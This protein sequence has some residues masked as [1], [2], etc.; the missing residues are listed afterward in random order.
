MMA[1]GPASGAPNAR[2]TI[3]EEGR[4]P[5]EE[6]ASLAVREGWRPRPE[7]GAHRWFA[8]RFGSAVRAILTGA[9][10]PVDGE[11]WDAYYA[12]TDWTGR[13]VLD[14]FVGGGTSV[15]EARRLG[16]RVI[17]V[18]VDPVACAITGWQ[19][20]A[21]TTPDLRPALNQL[22]VRVGEALAPYYRTTSPGHECDVLHFFWVQQVTCRECGIVAEAHP[23]YQL[24]H[25]AEGMRQWAFCRHCHAIQD[26]PRTSDE[27]W[28][29][30]CCATTRVAEGVV[31]YGRFTCPCCRQRERLIDSAARL[32]R[33]QWRLF[34]L[35]VL[36][37]AEGR[38]RLSPR[39]TL[40]RATDTDRANFAAAATALRQRT[41]PDGTVPWI[42]ERRIPTEQRA[43]DRVL[44][45]GYERYRDLFNSR[46]LLHLSC[47]A[48]AIAD[49]DG[50]ARD[51]M[52][53]AFSDHLTTNCMLT[54]YAFGWR[55]LA[56][57][58]SVRAYRHVVRPVELNPWLDRIGRGTFP[59]A[60]RQVQRAADAARA[61]R[62]PT[63]DGG[64][65]PAP[66]R[67][68]SRSP[69]Q[70]E[71]VVA[72]ARRL[73]FIADASVD[74]VLTDP[75]YFDNIPYAELSDFFRPWL[76]QFGLVRSEGALRVTPLDNLAALDR[77]ERTATRFAQE[78]AVCMREVRRVLAPAGKLA[79]T[80]QHSTAAG[81]QALASALN[82]AGFR[83]VQIFPLLGDRTAGL[84]ARAGTIRWDAVF[85]AAPSER[86]ERRRSLEV[87]EAAKVAADRHWRRWYDRLA[88]L[89]FRE[90][91]RLNLRRAC[92]VAAALSMFSPPEALGATQ[93]LVSLLR[94]A[95]EEPSVGEEPACLT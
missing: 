25:Q 57:L 18:D 88:D 62:E 40:L 92:L 70:A 9:A 3:L 76:Q 65:R 8:R 90:P 72:D 15:A 73:H 34:A 14:P 19:L 36:E 51:A 63:L 31:R 38:R 87:S 23:H 66:G 91:D 75:P 33:P 2:A 24:A 4:L 60:V 55:R 20:A 42:P 54:Q 22:Q 26:L 47:L 12:G 67:A 71:I 44:R 53:L 80:Y 1:A 95:G 6:L 89:P 69:S 83:V 81:W 77:D 35:E 7:Y 32:G 94:A 5:V 43:D 50:G 45:Y 17:G 78:L 52:A 21:A 74:F 11:F 82:D 68:E 85:L 48:E 93:S 16:A 79:F 61:P 58:F 13:T 64:F 56:P 30:R 29:A 37:P 84:H 39:R 28:C 86:Y 41:R 49:L 27:L 46:Q 59:N 10:L